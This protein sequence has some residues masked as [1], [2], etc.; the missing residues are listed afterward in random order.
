MLDNEVRN[1]KK[2]TVFKDAKVM[3]SALSLG[4]LFPSSPF[5]P[6]S[7]H[8]QGVVAVTGQKGWTGVCG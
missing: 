4:K 1:T 8:R 5:S 2:T 3:P 7:P 6:P